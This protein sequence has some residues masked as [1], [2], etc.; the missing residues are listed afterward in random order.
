LLAGAEICYTLLRM[1]DAADRSLNTV[2]APSTTLVAAYSY[3][4]VTSWRFS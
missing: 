3:T 4:Y 2:G 1:C